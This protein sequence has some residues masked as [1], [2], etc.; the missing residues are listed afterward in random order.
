MLVHQIY[1]TPEFQISVR[2]PYSAAAA[3]LRPSLHLF[4]YST[5]DWFPLLQSASPVSGGVGNLIYEWRF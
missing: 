5:I 3:S 1:G 2:L 4:S